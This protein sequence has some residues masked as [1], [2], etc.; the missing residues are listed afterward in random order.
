[1]TA[2]GFIGPGIMGAPMI[3]NLVQAG[4]TVQAFGRS[5]SSRRRIEESGATPVQSPREAARGVEVL[6][7]MLPDTPDVESVMLGSSE[8]EDDGVA[9]AMQ[10]GQTYIDM[11]SI[12]PHAA[13]QIHQRLADANVSAIDAP[14]SGG[15]A[16]AIDGT[17]SIM[18]GG[19]AETVEAVRPV[20]AAMGAAITHVGP[21]GSGQ[22][23]KAANQLIVAANI[24][25]VAEAIVLLD[26]AGADVEQALT[27]IAGGLAGSTVLERKRQA[28]ISGAF[29]PGFRIDLHNK[30]L[31]IVRDTADQAAVGLPLTAVVSQLMVAAAARGYGDRDHSALLQLTRDLND[32]N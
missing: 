10:P 2:I 14:V 6:I 16:A 23:A 13:R 1:M 21:A 28:F 15:E 4:H 3:A 12:A 7:T 26:A 18:A 19:D 20:L 31:R 22:L 27:A 9:D 24:Q 30:D 25:A 11:S 17:L 8:H 32:A 5:E 29:E